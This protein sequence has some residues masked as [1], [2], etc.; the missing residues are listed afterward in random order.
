MSGPW[1]QQQWAEI[2]KR[3]RKVRDF[4]AKARESRRVRAIAIETGIGSG[5]R[6]MQQARYF[7]TCARW[8][9][10]KLRHLADETAN[11]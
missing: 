9:E 8:H 4:R 1:T 3:A 2:V 10:E 11:P 6:L 7:E 5:A